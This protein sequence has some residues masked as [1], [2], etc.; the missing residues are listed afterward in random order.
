[1]VE[2]VLSPRALA[3]AEKS[4]PRSLL[5]PPASEYIHVKQVP[6]PAE[7]NSGII[8]TVQV[9]SPID[10]ELRARLQLLA[11]IAREPTFDQLRTKEQL[12]Y[13]VMAGLTGQAGSMGFRFIVQS[14]RKPEYVE[15]RIE[16]F[17]DWLKTHLEGLS[18]EEFAM[19]KASLIAKKQETPK[20]LGEETRRY[21]DRITDKY[22][23]FDRRDTEIAQLDATTKDDVL[24]FF[25]DKIH[26]SSPTR[27]KLST[28]LVSTYTGVKFDPAAAQPL[29]M[30]FM[31]HGVPVD[32]AAI[33]TLLASKPDLQQVKDF[34]LA[35]IDQAAALAS[36]A[37]E[38]LKAM[39]NGLSGTESTATA[40]ANGE[41]A[42]TG[43]NIRPSNIYIDDID[44][45]KAGLVPSKAA[46]PVA[47]LAALAKL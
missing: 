46:M 26:Y 16:V 7:L 45:F 25:L 22:Y 43:V 8:Y 27:S 17:M 42:S 24:A 39:V 34:A 33:G 15:T 1:M 47:P 28:H 21:W 18:D 19:Q 13:I 11:Q 4:H 29:M 14:E 5:L 35:A 37:K 12:G 44:A 40:N 31:Q 9:G 38:Q 23:E 36:E 30:A 6:N 32:Q 20:N 2:R 41:T 3:E 10:K